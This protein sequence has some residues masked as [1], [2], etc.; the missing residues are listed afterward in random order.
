MESTSPCNSLIGYS[1][2]WPA[3]H[4]SDQNFFCQ[5]LAWPSRRDQLSFRL[6]ALDGAQDREFAAKSVLYAVNACLHWL[7]NVSGVYLIQ[8]LI[9]QQGLVDFF[10]YR[11][12]LPIGRRIVQIL[13]KRRR[14]QPI[15]RRHS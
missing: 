15:Q 14:K 9:G 2:K 10:S 4:W 1:L 3:A 6:S 8:L 13:R 12:L 11:P 7:N 5:K